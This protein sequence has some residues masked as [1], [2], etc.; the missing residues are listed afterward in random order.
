MGSV[1]A[2]RLSNPSAGDTD[3]WSTFNKSGMA[4]GCASRSGSDRSSVSR[5]PRACSIRASSTRP[6]SIMSRM[7]RGMSAQASDSNETGSSCCHSPFSYTS[8]VALRSRDVFSAPVTAKRGA[9]LL[10]ALGIADV[11]GFISSEEPRKYAVLPFDNG[12]CESQWTALG[13]PIA[14]WGLRYF[15]TSAA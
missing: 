6:W 1:P 9:G 12:S 14:S 4:D 3:I 10:P 15:S 11:P 13:S 5:F 8:P 7:P 2:S